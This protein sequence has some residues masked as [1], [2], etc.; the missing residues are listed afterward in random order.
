MDLND[1]VVLPKSKSLQFGARSPQGLQLETVTLAQQGNELEEKLQ[2]LKESMRREKDERGHSGI[3]YRKAEQLGSIN[4]SALMQDSKKIQKHSSMSKV[5]IRVLK[6]EPLTGNEWR[7]EEPL[8]EEV[9]APP[10]LPLCETCCCPQTK[11]SRM[12]G[13]NCGQG[14]VRADQQMFIGNYG[15]KTRVEMT[16]KEQNKDVKK[17]F[18]NSLL[19]G[20]YDEEESAKSFQEA[21][22]EWRNRR[23][24]GAVGPVTMWTQTVSMSG[25]AA[26]ADFLPLRGHEGAEGWGDSKVPIKVV[27][28]ESR[29]SYLDRLL[30]KKHRRSPI[31]ARHR[32]LAS[33]TDLISMNNTGIEEE[34]EKTNSEDEM[35]SDSLDLALYEEDSSDQESNED[36]YRRGGIEEESKQVLQAQSH[37]SGSHQFS[38]LDEC[39]HLDLYQSDSKVYDDHVNTPQAS[40]I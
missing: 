14:D 21:L 11:Q 8:K 35:S 25:I 27:F 34:Q 28:P 40:Q 12:R 37:R 10:H 29:L 20:E 31:E 30:L 9:T 15:E 1:F 2:K 39:P 32:L 23:C 3:S 16:K 19:G 6:D 36:G 4:S 24:D 26:Q 5:K 38:H 33:N 18:A 17:A 7:T 22:K 13:P